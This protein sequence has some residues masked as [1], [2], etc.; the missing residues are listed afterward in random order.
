MNTRL[1]RRIATAIEKKP[2]QYNQGA[3]GSGDPNPRGPL[4]ACGT[5]FCVAGWAVALSS[6]AKYLPDDSW[7]L[8]ETAREKL[9]LTVG[10]ADVLFSGGWYPG[11]FWGSLGV[12]NE[13][14]RKIMADGV[15]PTAVQAAA[16]LRH[17]ADIHE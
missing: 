2:K 9:D 13:D 14:H 10:E 11:E 16:M 6:R 5:A 12:S 15:H 3:Y 1:L 8:S 17:I 7:N 4:R